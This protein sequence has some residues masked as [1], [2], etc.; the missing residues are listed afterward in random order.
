VVAGRLEYNNVIGALNLLPH[1]TWVHDVTG[2]SP[3]PGGNFIEGRHAITAGL[4]ASLRSKWDFDVSY[5]QYGGAGQYNLLKDRN[6]VAASI[7]YSF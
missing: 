1:A 4:G 2:V 5:T 7:K 3:G 6:F